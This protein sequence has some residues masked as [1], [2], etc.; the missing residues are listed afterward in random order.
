MINLA[1]IKK[2]QWDQ[3]N[4]NKNLAKHKVSDEESEEVFFDPRKR[5]FKDA[6]HSA[7]ENR[8]ILIGQ[9]KLKRLL[10]IVFTIRRNK[11]RVISARNLNKKERK[12]L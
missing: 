10:F 4:R 9:T 2:F 3:G 7:Q 8:Y 11:V 5:I 12:L 1:K 6:L